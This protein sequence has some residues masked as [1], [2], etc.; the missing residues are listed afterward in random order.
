MQPVALATSAG[1]VSGAADARFAALRFTVTR[2][3]DV[4]LP[5]LRAPA[6]PLAAGR[7]SKDYR[8]MLRRLEALQALP[9]EALTSLTGRA[10]GRPR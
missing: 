3:T 9:P 5:R 7:H 2:L 6:P 1:P 4:H 8:D 10:S